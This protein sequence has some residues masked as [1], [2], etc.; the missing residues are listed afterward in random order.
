M[1]GFQYQTDSHGGG[2]DAEIGVKSSP[3]AAGKGYQDEA[4]NGGDTE[5]DTV[6]EGCAE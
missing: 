1:V 4:G 5:C 3:K 2:R 6:G